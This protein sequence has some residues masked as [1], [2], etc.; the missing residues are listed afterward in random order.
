MSDQYIGEIRMFSGDYAPEGWAKC[1]GQRL[2]ITGNEALFSLLGITYGG[3]GVTNFAL[4]DLR[5]RIPIH[6]GTP[7][8]LGSSGGSETVV[9]SVNELPMHT[10]TVHAYSRPGDSTNPAGAIWSGSL[11]TQYA[12]AS[13]T[14]AMSPACISAAGSAQ[15]HDNMMPYGTLT[16]MIALRGLYPRS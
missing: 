14:G 8:T 15:P 1:D 7:Y 13:P 12:K 6:T 4:P 11:I 5:G 3:D 9:L 2:P 10:H 16:F